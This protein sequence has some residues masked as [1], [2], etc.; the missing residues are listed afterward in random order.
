L[1]ERSLLSTF[2]VIDRGDAGSGSGLQGDLRY[3]IDTA[4]SNA[5]LSNRIVFQPG[6]AGTITL[7]QG[8]LV[9]TKPLEIDGPG[10]DLLTVS[11]NQQSGVFDIEA[12]AGRTVLLADLTIADGTGAGRDQF[13]ATVGGGLFNDAATL[14]LEH[15]TFSRNSVPFVDFGTGGGGAIFN[16]H[17]T[18]TLTDSILTDNQAGSDGTH[19]AP[20]GAIE[21]QGTMVVH[22]S[23]IS[24]NRAMGPAI[25]NGGDL[26]LVG[27][28]MTLDQCVIAD[29]QGF[30]SNANDNSTLMLDQCVIADNTSGIGSL[31]SLTITSCTVTG[32]TGTG[33]F[34]SGRA[35]ITDSSI[36]NNHKPDLGGGGIELEL[37]EMTV[38]GSTI[39]GNTVDGDGGGI[40]LLAG[41]LHLT[42]STISGNVARIGGGI[43]ATTI[44]G[45]N[46]LLDVSNSTITLNRTAATIFGGAGG[47]G[48]IWV[49][50]RAAF[51]NTIIAGNQIAIND[52]KQGPDVAGGVV[53]E[54]YNL[55]GQTD[56][57]TG[58]TGTDLQGTSAHPL[59]PVLGPLQDNGGPTSTHALLLGSPALG[60]GDPANL[61]TLDQRGTVR[62]GFLGTP[63]DIGAFE[64]EPASQ[65]RLVAPASV[66]AGQP[67]ALTV[68]ALDFYGN[69]ASTYTGTVHF[70]STDLFAQ[71]PDDTAFSGDG[72][73]T[74]TF[75]VAL[76][77]PGPQDIQ[78]VDTASPSVSGTVTVDVSDFTSPQGGVGAL[79]DG[80]A[81]SKAVSAGLPDIRFP[82]APTVAAVPEPTSAAIRVPIGP[83]SPIPDA[84][85]PAGAGNDPFQLTGSL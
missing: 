36:L 61:M 47:G 26:T 52:P 79:A 23:T 65:F 63:T 46:S 14:I 24:G 33:L 13:G 6:L 55:I 41:V 73:G 42:N 19:G 34:V 16:C 57:S 56:G 76:L 84:F 85:M 59:D 75:T 27:A 72:A 43:Y 81:A 2:T 78:V 20:G 48:G 68:V 18:V 7:T 11:G 69:V 8:K 5:D 39:A 32:N 21:N 40:L 82:V 17:G 37:G 62:F 31:G 70:S 71:L 53:S 45:L 50:S 67:F 38:S 51:R 49:G 54:G 80:D 58:W 66:F 64:A 10:A 1:E 25:G 15:T 29:N 4:N 77:T 30:I 35:T 9:V 3:C 12:P 60:A 74:H 83:D 22:R 44:Q 28:T